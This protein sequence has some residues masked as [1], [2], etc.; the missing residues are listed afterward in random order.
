M[1][2]MV[3]LMVAQVVVMVAAKV[4]VKEVPAVGYLH[5]IFFIFV[6]FVIILMVTPQ[7]HSCRAFVLIFSITL[8]TSPSKM[9]E[10]RK[11]LFGLTG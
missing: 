10:R 6:F 5:T 11:P 8:E 2:L 9:E 3:A 1:A 7:K 4:L